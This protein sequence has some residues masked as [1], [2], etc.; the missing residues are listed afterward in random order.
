M[1]EVEQLRKVVAELKLDNGK[2][3]LIRV[4]NEIVKLL[5]PSDDIA[6]TIGKKGTH[7][8]VVDRKGLAIITTSQD[9]YLPFLSSSE[10]RISMDQIPEDVARKAANDINGILAQLMDVLKTHSRRSPKYEA[11]ASE[12]E[13]IVKGERYNS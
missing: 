10:K 9:E 13:A 2:Q 5:P 6:I 12:V 3:N 4:L 7:E 8:Y 1:T 11:I